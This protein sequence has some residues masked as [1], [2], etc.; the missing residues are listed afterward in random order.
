MSVLNKGTR[1]IEVE[2][3]PAR[4]SYITKE[5]ELLTEIANISSIELKDAVRF[6]F[7]SVRNGYGVQKYLDYPERVK[8]L[9]LK[10]YRNDKDIIRFIKAEV[11]H[12]I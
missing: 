5:D 1:D 11:D 12:L 10:G 7:H 8:I 9:C 4:N 2:N 3:I 6:E